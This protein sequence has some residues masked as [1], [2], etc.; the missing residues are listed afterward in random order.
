[1]NLGQMRH[2]G[3]ID[4]SGIEISLDGRTWVGNYPDSASAYDA[5]LAY[6]LAP[7][8]PATIREAMQAAARDYCKGILD[9]IN[10]WF[11]GETYGIVVYVIDRKTGERIEERDMETWG[12]YG[13][14]DAV[15]ALEGEM[16]SLLSSLTQPI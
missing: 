11:N 2:K 16:L 1:M 8:S 3:E 5:M 15:D 6:N 14:D 12:Y 10:A 9:T 7:P 4:E 13:T